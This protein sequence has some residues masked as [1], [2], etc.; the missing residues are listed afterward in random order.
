MNADGLVS[1]CFLDWGRKLVIGDVRQQ[2]MKEIWNSDLMNA[3]RLQH[4]E[5]RRR[6]NGVCGNCGQ[7]SHCLPDN[8]D[9]HRAAAAGEVQEGRSRINPD[10]AAPGGRQQF[11]AV[12]AE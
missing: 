10:V 8:I 7:L 11:T 12:A 1:S 9:A 5:G 3:L 6:Q 4:L 2:S